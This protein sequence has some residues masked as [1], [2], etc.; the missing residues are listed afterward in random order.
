MPQ[1]LYTLSLERHRKVPIVLTTITIFKQAHK[2]QKAF[3]GVHTFLIR[4]KI[5]KKWRKEGGGCQSYTIVCNGNLTRHTQ[6]IFLSFHCT[7]SLSLL[8]NERVYFIF[9][10][11]RPLR[12][13][14]RIM[15]ISR[16]CYHQFQ[17]RIEGKEG[18][19]KVPLPRVA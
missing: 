16:Q 12:E 8:H 2:Y 15:G 13:K 11:H 4:S 14:K 6:L 9:F 5:Y 1:I 18:W 10:I 3:S 19:K 7:T 17:T